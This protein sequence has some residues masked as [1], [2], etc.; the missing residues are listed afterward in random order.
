MMVLG[1]QAIFAQDDLLGDF[2][3]NREAHCLPDAG[4]VER[5]LRDLAAQYGRVRCQDVAK[6]NVRQEFQGFKLQD[7]HQIEAVDLFGRQS[8]DGRAR[9][10]P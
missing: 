5:F 7:I 10:F 6:L 8:I 2:R 1:G 9:I 4:I 3:I